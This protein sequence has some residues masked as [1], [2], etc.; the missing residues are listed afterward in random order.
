MLSK[1]TAPSFRFRF[2]SIIQTNPPTRQTLRA[3]LRCQLHLKIQPHRTK[4][5]I[6]KRQYQGYILPFPPRH[7]IVRLRYPHEKLGI[8]IWIVAGVPE[9]CGGYYF[10]VVG[11]RF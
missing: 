7:R 8:V 5:R 3:P 9:V 6:E 10:V 2:P 11:V 4:L 1:S